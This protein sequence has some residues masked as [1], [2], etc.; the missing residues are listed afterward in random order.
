MSVIK[1]IHPRSHLCLT[2][3]SEQTAYHLP[4]L[5]VASVQ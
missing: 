1:S 2:V 5:S 4:H 3:G